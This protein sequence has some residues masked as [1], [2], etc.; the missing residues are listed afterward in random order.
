MTEPQEDTST[1]LCSVNS[2]NILITEEQQQ[3]KNATLKQFDIREIQNANKDI[4]RMKEILRQQ[5]VLSIDQTKQESHLVRR[6][7][8]ERN[9]LSIP[10]T[11]IL[12]RSTLG[13]RLY[14]H[15]LIIT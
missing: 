4:K 15:H 5:A 9:K 12:V 11:D 13:N 2:I 10:G 3:N 6:L 8:R 1:W 7:L 14:Y